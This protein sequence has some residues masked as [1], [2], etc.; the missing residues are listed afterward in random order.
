[1][2]HFLSLALL[3]VLSACSFAD[4]APT[5]KPVL[6]VSL[7]A[8]APTSNPFAGP[9]SGAEFIQRGHDAVIALNEVKS[10]APLAKGWSFLGF[11]FGQVPNLTVGFD[12]FGGYDVKDES[13]VA[14]FAGVVRYHF[15]SNFS[16]FGG[17]GEKADLSKAFQINQLSLTNA[18][19]IVGGSWGF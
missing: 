2:K 1:M 6:A 12:L 8:T 5:L 3:A 16:L 15:N 7:Q 9:W 17:I 18:G 11:N 19:L 4:S 13:A 10:Y 14:G